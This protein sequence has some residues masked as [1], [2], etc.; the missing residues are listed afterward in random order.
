[1]G[2]NDANLFDLCRKVCRTVGILVQATKILRVQKNRNLEKNYGRF[3]NYFFQFIFVSNLRI[4]KKEI[5]RSEQILTL[6][7]L[8]WVWGKMVGN[9]TVSTYQTFSQLQLPFLIFFHAVQT[10]QQHDVPLSHPHQDL[11]Q[12]FTR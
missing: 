9:P 8:I 2:S 7:H 6:Y 12:V 10:I 1:V 5:H 3:Y 4:W 11:E